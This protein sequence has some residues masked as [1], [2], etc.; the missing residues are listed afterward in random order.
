MR[1]QK[2]SGFSLIEVLLAMLLLGIGVLGA[3]RAH[4][5]ALQTRHDTALMSGAVHL[6][7]SLA[8]RMLAN[9]AVEGSSVP[10]PYLALDYDALGGA[11]SRPAAMCHGPTQ[12]DPTQL[13]AFDVYQIAESVHD[14]FPGGRVKVCRDASVVAADGTLTWSCDGAA[15]APVV[16]KLGWRAKGDQPDNPRFAPA[17]AILALGASA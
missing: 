14:A 11:P 15:G 6:A 12:C 4:V 13:A 2:V 16:I 17:V 1:T 3:L 9:R 10:D 7:S 5:V 8:E